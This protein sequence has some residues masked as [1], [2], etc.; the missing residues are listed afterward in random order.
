MAV[1]VAEHFD[2][3]NIQTLTSA[4]RRD[5]ERRTLAGEIEAGARLSEAALAGG[6]GVVR[7]P[8]REGASLEQE[9]PREA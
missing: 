6:L 2:A 4:R 8:V 9:E 1:V 7:D 3:R 5:T